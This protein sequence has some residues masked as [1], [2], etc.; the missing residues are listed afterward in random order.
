MSEK[1]KYQNFFVI[2]NTNGWK[3]CKLLEATRLFVT[4][5]LEVME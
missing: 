4:A 1:V 5:K 3:P 2:W